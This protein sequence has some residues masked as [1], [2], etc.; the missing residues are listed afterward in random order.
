MDG[1]NIPNP[2]HFGSLGTS[3]GPVSMINANLLAKSDFLT[4]AFPAAYAN[5]LGSVFDLRL[6]KGNDEKHEFLVQAGFNGVEAGCRRSLQQKVQSLLP[7][8]LPLL[9]FRNHV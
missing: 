1:V 7:G 2:N 6:R 3:G 4:G 9:A 8:K 5:A